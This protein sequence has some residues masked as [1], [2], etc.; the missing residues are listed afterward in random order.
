MRANFREK[1]MRARSTGTLIVS[2]AVFL[3]AGWQS[4]LADEVVSVE[5]VRK[6]GIQ[7]KQAADNAEA[8]KQPAQNL[9]VQF[10][11]EL[12]RIRLAVSSAHPDRKLDAKIEAI[13]LVFAKL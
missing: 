8:G 2:A 9:M 3:L 5:A 13:G 7:I 4:C 10:E 6:L 1:S 12:N 11:R